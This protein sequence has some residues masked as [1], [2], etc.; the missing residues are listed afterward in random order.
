MSP[1]L[2]IIFSFFLLLEGYM[3]RGRKRGRERILS[4]LPIQY[5]TGLGPNLTTLRS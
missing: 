1:Y 4:R 2:L 5:R 3:G